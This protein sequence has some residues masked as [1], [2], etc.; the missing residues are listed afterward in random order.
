M[1]VTYMHVCVCV[2][3]RAQKLLFDEREVPLK[4]IKSLFIIVHVNK[5]V[6]TEA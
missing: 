2:C 1:C 4:Q 3:V 5:N 6:S